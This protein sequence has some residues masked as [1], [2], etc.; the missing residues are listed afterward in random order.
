MAALAL[1]ATL[2]VAQQGGTSGA[3]PT[4]APQTA[5]G[6]DA[7]GAPL[8]PEA[9]RGEG[10]R[11]G[12]WRRGNP[13][14]RARD[15]R[16]EFEDYAEHDDRGG[17][18]RR[19]GWGGGPRW[20][21]DDWRGRSPERWGFD[22]S[23]GFGGGQ[24]GPM[25]MGPRAMGRLCGPDGGRI[26]GFMLDRLE[27]I[28]KPAEAQRQAFERLTEAAAK[29]Q[30][31]ARATCPTGERPVTPPGRLAAAEKR[32]EALLEAIRTVRPALDE[33]YASLSEEQKARLYAASPRPG[34]REH[35]RGWRERF[36]GG[37]D[38]ER[39]RPDGP[40]ESWRDESRDRERDGWRGRQRWRDEGQRSRDRRD[41]DADDDRDY[42]RDGWPDRW[43]GPS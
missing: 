1:T 21:E 40:R 30:D 27:R 5:P 9:G 18:R 16:R 19:D 11:D 6:D 20:R 43:R 37:D 32:L 4:Q 35:M 38:F 13:D 25:M 41:Y 28:T 39:R 15:D 33:F 8:R 29:A 42:D 26:I 12:R 34:W 17:W 31:I 2:A 24:R 3:P 14:E 10:T 7:A 23:R 36:G 22:S